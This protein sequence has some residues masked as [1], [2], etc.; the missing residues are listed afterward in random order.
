[1][2]DDLLLLPVE[3]KERADALRNRQILLETASRLFEHDGVEN[4]TMSAV[5]E[6]AHV[7]KGTLYRHFTDKGALILALLD[8]DMHDLQARVFAYLRQPLAP[9]DKL[10]WFLG[11]VAMFVITHNCLLMNSAEARPE[12][13]RTHPAHSWWWQTIRG[14]LSQTDCEQPDTA[15]DVLYLM[16]DV[17]TIRYQLETRHYS[18]ERILDGLQHTLKKLAN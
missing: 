3:K 17:Q 16:L 2:V 13:L 1:M 12:A 5:A 4:V 7:G 8:V 9:L 14:L 15:A 6:A 18:T 10:H 11:E